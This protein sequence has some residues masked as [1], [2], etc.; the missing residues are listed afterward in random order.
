MFKP[1]PKVVYAADFETTT[2]NPKSVEVWSAEE[3]EINPNVPADSAHC[4]HQTNIADFIKWAENLANMRLHLIIYFHNEK[5]DGSYILDY[6][7]KNPKYHPF[8][9]TA[10]DGTEHLFDR[11]GFARVWDMDPRDYSYM[12]SDK[13][14]IYSITIRTKKGLIEIRDSLKILPFS[15]RKIAKDFQTPH[16]KLEMVYSGKYPGYNPTPKEMKYIEND[17]YVLKEALEI[18]AN[19][20]GVEVTEIPL[21]IAS[22]AMQDYKRE[23]VTQYGKDQWDIMFPSQVKKI[24]GAVEGD[25]TFDEY[26]RHS[27]KGGWCY[28]S[29][30][31]KGKVIT[32]KAVLEYL[33][34]TDPKAA[35]RYR[36]NNKYWGFVYDVN[37]LYPSMMHSYSGSFYPIGEGE[38]HPGDFTQAELKEMNKGRLYGFLH[39]RLTFHVKQN[40]LPC[41]QIKNNFNYPSTEWLES[42]DIYVKDIKANVPNVVDLYLTM[43]DWELIRD[44]YDLDNVHVVSVLLYHTAQGFFDAYVDKWM[45]V[46]QREKG[47]KRAWAKLMLN[48]CYGKFSTSTNSSYMY[49]YYDKTKQKVQRIAVPLFDE[50]RAVYIPVGAAITAWARNFTIRH[51]QANFNIFCYADTDSIHCIGTKDMARGIV[52][53]PVA[54]CAWKNE[55]AWRD[56]I[57][58][59]QKRYIERVV[60]ADGKDQEK[61]FYNIKCCGMSDGAK[62]ILDKW[63]RA[64]SKH[65]YDFKAGLVVPG[66]LKGHIVDGGTFL[67]EQDF[68][69]H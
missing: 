7:E 61:W 6:L 46:K 35:K 63:L 31:W 45:A 56:A 20:H 34:K 1:T 12:I 5:F 44:H 58:A 37:S 4:H 2:D 18:V 53:D 39:V 32:Q 9:F 50:D 13:N 68:C 19:L 52:E 67:Q 23:F 36:K 65:L 55:T 14:V 26:V 10:T 41:I 38:Y 48:S 3:I 28:C 51:A 49:C 11:D 17:V 15:L 29:P 21:T 30:K 59:G 22:M 60:Q 16:K 24:P 64:R 57:F 33:E 54:L 47:A 43:T 66:N 40:H 27:Y 25:I 69:F 62:N 8:S 42:S